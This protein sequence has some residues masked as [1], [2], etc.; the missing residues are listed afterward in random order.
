M[1]YK[2]IILA[3]RIGNEDKRTILW[4][5]GRR[6]GNEDK[7]NDHWDPRKENSDILSAA[8]AHETLHR[9]AQVELL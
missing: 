3:R 9:V 2:E 5:Q 7:K 4:T 1:S 6:K 8:E